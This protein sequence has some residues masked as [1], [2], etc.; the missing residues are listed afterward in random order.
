MQ[1]NKMGPEIFI[2]AILPEGHTNLLAKKKTTW[3]PNKVKNAFY[4]KGDKRIGNDFPWFKQP[5]IN[6]TKVLEFIGITK[7]GEP[8]L[9]KKDSNTSV[10]VK[11]MMMLAERMFVNQGTRE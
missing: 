6:P 2:S 4:N 1:I 8:N 9:Y 3:I 10:N 7:R 5:N 11:D